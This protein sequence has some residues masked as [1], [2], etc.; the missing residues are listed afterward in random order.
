MTCGIYLI[1]HNPSGRKYVGQARNVEERW[2]RHRKGDTNRYLRE[3]VA[4]EG[5]EALEFLLLEVAEPE[6][7]NAREIFWIGQHASMYPQGFNLTAGGKVP[8][9]VSPEV[10]QILSQAQRKAWE[11]D[12][13]R[14]QRQAELGRQRMAQ[15]GYRE[16]TVCSPEARAKIAAGMKERAGEMNRKRWGN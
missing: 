3:I 11:G 12:P 9:S 10:R 15:D 1:N 5:P 2:E 13:K 4:T 7:L 8:D 14:K 16:R 6:N